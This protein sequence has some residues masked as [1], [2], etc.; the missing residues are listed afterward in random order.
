MDRQIEYFIREADLS[1]NSKLTVKGFL[2]SKCYS[3]QNLKQ[4]KQNPFGILVN[5]MPVHMNT[6]LSQGDQLTVNIHEASPSESITP[7]RLPLSILYEDE[8]ILVLI[9]PAGMPI[10]PSQNNRDNTLANAL[11]YYFEQKGQAF[12]FRCINRL[13]RDTSGLTIVAK[14]FVSAGILGSFVANKSSDNASH[15]LTREYLAISRG[16]V[17]PPCGTITA[18]LG[19]KPGSIIERCI[20]FENGES[21]ITHYRVIAEKN[22]YS[23]ISL[24][25]E[26]GR[27]HQIRIHLKHIGHPIVGDY[28][29]NP[30]Y[31]G[32]HRQALHS[33]R[34]SFRH[35]ITWETMNFTAVLPEDMRNLLL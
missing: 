25:L 9:K 29:Y 13:D 32:I 11:A 34:L 30:D 22:G 17:T 2:R 14:H 15:S 21:A 18:P 8:D 26:T 19:R 4:L 10:H 31:E 7:I 27:T 3:V 12:V 23:L 16:S 33:Y 1:A 5:N 6:T 35:P 28:L 20:D 24:I